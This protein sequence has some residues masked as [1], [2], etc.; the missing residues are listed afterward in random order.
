M[1][2]REY[3]TQRDR[4]L[5]FALKVNA[6]VKE[7]AR[8]DDLWEY[9]PEPTTGGRFLERWNVQGDDAEAFGCIRPGFLLGVSPFPIVRWDD[10]RTLWDELR[11][12]E[13]A[14]ADT[15]TADFRT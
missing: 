5:A 12:L 15:R 13:Y 14:F 9:S 11:V 7:R 10:D 6:R 2:G 4:Q 8:L 1:K 3:E